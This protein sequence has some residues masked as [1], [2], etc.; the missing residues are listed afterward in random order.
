MNLWHFTIN[1]N[2]YSRGVKDTQYNHFAVS[3]IYRVSQLDK[4]KY[5][6]INI[7]VSV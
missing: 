7:I 3:I 5:V 4:N 2:D 1:G 6:L